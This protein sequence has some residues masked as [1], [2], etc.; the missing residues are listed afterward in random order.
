[1]SRGSSS[2]WTGMQISI[3]RTYDT[4]PTPDP[5][6]VLDLGPGRRVGP[7]GSATDRDLAVSRVISRLEVRT[8]LQLCLQFSRG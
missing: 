8:N 5:T 1:M 6:A 7:P 2:I 3:A 4:A